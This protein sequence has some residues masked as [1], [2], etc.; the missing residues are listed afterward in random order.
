[1]T[2]PPLSRSL[3]ARASGVKLA[4]FDVDGVM[5]DGRL[6]LSDSGDEIKAF[7]SLDGHGLKMLR[8]SGV[9]IAIITGRTSRLV[10]LRAQ[11]LG[12][13]HLFQGSEDKLATF[14]GLLEMLSLEPAEASYMGDDVTDLPILRRCGLAAT[15]PDAPQIVKDH[16]QYVAKRGGGRGAVREICELIMH[17]QSTLAAEMERYLR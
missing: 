14:T 12:I 8:Q 13:E 7:N 9:E 4:V 6:Y 3:K 17:A 10:E 16:C 1:L 2:N 11:N 15:V 5:T